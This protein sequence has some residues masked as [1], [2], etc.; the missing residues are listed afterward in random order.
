[1]QLTVLDNVLWAASFIGHVALLCILMLRK[2]WRAF[3]VFTLYNAYHVIQT[4]VLF[5]VYHYGSRHAYGKSYWALAVGAFIFQLGWIYE[6]AKDVLRPT[7]T[8]IRDARAQFLLWSGLG[9]LL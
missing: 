8:W 7:G 3:P 2:R 1:M 4:A 9:I 6:I 5:L